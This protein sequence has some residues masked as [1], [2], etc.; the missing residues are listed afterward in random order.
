LCVLLVAGGY[1]DLRWRR[2]PNALTLPCLAVGFVLQFA[3]GG[4][5]GLRSSFVAAAIAF[6]VGFVLFMLHVIGGGDAK[7]VAAIGA[8]RGPGF[9]VESMLWTAVVSLVISGALLLM[10]G[11][12]F[13]FFGRLL[14][15]G[16]RALIY[17]L[18]PVEED[19]VKEGGHKIPFA[20]I[21][22][23]GTLIAMVAEWKG[24]TLWRF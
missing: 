6:A 3:I 13:P 2:V 12:L 16:Y 21:I 4:F 14:R 1:T 22:A 8:I 24:V 23:L 7:F 19:V 18:V 10:K 5:A 9:L 15:A 17:Q 11:D 20:A